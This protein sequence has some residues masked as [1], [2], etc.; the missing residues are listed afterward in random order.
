MSSINVDQL[1]EFFEFRADLQD[2]KIKDM[3]DKVG[4][5]GR[6]VDTILVKVNT[7]WKAAVAIVGTMAL[8]I[9]KMLGIY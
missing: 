4:S 1:K 7:M 6:N 8:I 5:I 2:S 3:G 9:L